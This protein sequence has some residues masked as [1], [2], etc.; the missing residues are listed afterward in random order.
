VERSDPWARLI[1][2]AGAIG[3]A[4]TLVYV[5]G[6]ASLSLR[7]EGFGLPG[8]QAA[9]QTPREV[10]L[11]AG[12]RTLGIWALLGLALVLSLRALPDETERAL[13]G[14]LRRPTGFLA[15]A[16]VALV[17]LLALKVWWPLAT[18]GAV[19]A[20]VLASVHWKAR[21]LARILASALAVALVA[22]AYEADRITYYVERT[23]VTP[24]STTGQGGDRRMC[25]ALVGQQDR[26]FYLGVPLEATGEGVSEGLSQDLVFIPAAH[27]GDARSTKQLARVTESRADARRRWLPARLLDLRVR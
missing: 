12:L 16:A 25:G 4:V 18:Y 2:A 17:L 20:I 27:V 10:L 19:V 6:G 1:A 8:Q 5:I 21:P 7:Y 22:V 24:A 14:R 9:A 3:A 15:A 26:G 11:A 13:V 23:C